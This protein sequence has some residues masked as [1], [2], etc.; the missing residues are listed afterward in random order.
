LAVDFLGRVD[1]GS[2]VVEVRL[3]CSVFSKN[4][5]LAVDFLDVVEVRL[6]C[7]VFSKNFGL[8]VDFLGR[9][10]VGGSDVVE[11]RLKGS[12][13]VIFFIRGPKFLAGIEFEVVF[14]IGS[15]VKNKDVKSNFG[16]EVTNSG[17]SVVK[18]PELNVGSC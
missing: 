10:D 1:V 4:F 9:V 16:V 12:F 11:V 6:N 7:S 8:A 17:K 3:N 13:V 15:Y 2:D 14:C 5:G 18:V